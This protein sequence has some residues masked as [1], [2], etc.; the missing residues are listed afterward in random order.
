MQPVKTSIL[1]QLKTAKVDGETVLVD[2]SYNKTLCAVMRDEGF[3]FDD[4]NPNSTQNSTRDSTRHGRTKQ[5][6]PRMLGLLRYDWKP[7]SSLSFVTPCVEV[8]P[9]CALSRLGSF[10]IECHACRLSRI[11]MWKYPS[12]LKILAIGLPPK[13]I[14]RKDS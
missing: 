5:A 7:D 14:L 4:S 2:P 13:P 12:S 8:S 10:V 9:S 11:R 1:A 6:N 3:L